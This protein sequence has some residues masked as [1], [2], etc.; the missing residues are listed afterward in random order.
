MGLPVGWLRDWIGKRNVSLSAVLVMRN[1]R[2]LK[3]SCWT[4]C[5]VCGLGKSSFV[6]LC[7]R[8]KRCIQLSAPKSQILW[9]W[10]QGV[11][12]GLCIILAQ[13]T[14]VSLFN[15][16]GASI[17]EV[18][19]GTCTGEHLLVI[20]LDPEIDATKICC[21][22]PMQIKGSCT[23]CG[24]PLLFETPWGVQEMAL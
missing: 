11:W 12:W 9:F 22:R 14:C 7:S 5:G 24:W 20:L 6:H 21:E 17:Y 19:T 13:C 10:E 23:F 18:P 2:H 1:W 16:S 4:A 15:F 3:G 8:K